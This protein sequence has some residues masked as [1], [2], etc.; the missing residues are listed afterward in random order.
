MPEVARLHSTPG[1]RGCPERQTRVSRSPPRVPARRRKVPAV[2]QIQ[3]FPM[4]ACLPPQ[5]HCSHACA[6]G[7]GLDTNPRMR[8][9]LEMVRGLAQG[10][11]R[12]AST[13]S[14]PVRT[15]A[16]VWNPQ[17][18]GPGDTFPMTG[19]PHLCFTSPGSIALDSSV[20]GWCCKSPRQRVGQKRACMAFACHC[21]GIMTGA[22]PIPRLLELGTLR[23]SPVPSGVH[24]PP[25]HSGSQPAAS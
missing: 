10:S 21:A 18:T 23:R 9:D 6:L 20:P 4:G 13:G 16:W 12:S 8:P 3:W 17:S 1:S 14:S 5:G 24:R 11:L 15:E 19:M 7:T 25:G 2:P 22:P